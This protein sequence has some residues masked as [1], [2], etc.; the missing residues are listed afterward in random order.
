METEINR[1]PRALDHMRWPGSGR[2]PE[3]S[4]IG[5]GFPL[6]AAWEFAQSPLYADWD[7]QWT[8]LLWTRFH[9]TVGDVMILLGAFWLTSLVFGTRRWIGTTHHAA[10]LFV[11]LGIG[12]TTWSEWFNTS[13]RASWGYAAAMPVIGGVGLAPVL[14]WMLLPPLVLWLSR[15]RTSQRTGAR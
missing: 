11:V 13:I 15:P 5:W 10:L 2:S 9:C 1:A 7:Q 12:Y 3:L 4:I 6:N 14:Q 8:Y